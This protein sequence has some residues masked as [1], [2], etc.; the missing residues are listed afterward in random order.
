MV[1]LIGGKL[2]F[3]LAEAAPV[4]ALAHRLTDTAEGDLVETCAP[5]EAIAGEIGRRIGTEGGVALIVDYGGRGITGDSFQAVHAHRKVD[6]LSTPGEADL[7][8]HVD[9]A[10][11]A[12][13]AA[14][15]VAS[16]PTPQGVF[17][18]R[19]GVTARAEA[20]LRGLPPGEARTSHIAAHR[21]LTHPDEM[22]SLF[23]ALALF[24]PGTPPPPGVDA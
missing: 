22:G 9:F 1:G 24:A 21:R 12:R 14:P 6:P 11:I 8:A 16:T 20:L 10:A 17:L 7:T 18:E 13:A 2:A 23:Q 4:A 5:A 19:L 15:A 3:G